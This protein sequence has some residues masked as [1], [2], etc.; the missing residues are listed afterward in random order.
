MDNYANEIIFTIG[1]RKEQGHPQ[2]DSWKKRGE[3]VNPSSDDT[4][5]IVHDYATQ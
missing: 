5:T 4:N 2:A 3:E 1:H